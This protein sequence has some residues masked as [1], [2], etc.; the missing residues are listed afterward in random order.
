MRYFT[1]I[2]LL[3]SYSKPIL[4]QENRKLIN[5]EIKLDSF[6][7]HDVHII[8]MTTNTGTISNDL[9][10]FTIPVTLGDRLSI[11]HLNLKNVTITITKKI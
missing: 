7:I 1:L 8:N 3:F 2:I 4:S 10:I 5:G 9:G 6:P 11:S